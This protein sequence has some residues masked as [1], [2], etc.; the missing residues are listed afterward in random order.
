MPRARRRATPPRI[1]ND[2]LESAQL[3]GL[4][5]VGEGSAGIAR[6]RAG[7]SFTYVN[8]QGIRV[9]HTETL[10]R[11]RSLAIPPAWTEVWICASPR[12]HVQAVGRDARRRKQY[13]YHPRWR[14]VRDAAKYARMLAFARALPAIRARVDRDLAR[15]GLP[16]EKVLAAVVRLLDLTLIRVGNAEYARQN[17]SFGL[18]TMRDEHVT[19]VGSTLSFH[20]RGKSGK[21][22]AVTIRDARLAR[23]VR[24]CQELPGRSLF[25]WIGADGVRQAI[26]SADVNAYLREAA[27]EE[28]TAKDF[29]TW[30][31]TVLAAM[32]L[33][34]GETFTSQRQARR[35]IA[36]AVA[37]VARRLGN[38]PAVCRKGYVH[39][40]VIDAYLDGTALH[41]FRRRALRAANGDGAGLSA[42]EAVV[43]GMLKSR[44]T[45][46]PETRAA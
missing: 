26:D 2:P 46:A 45:P 23:I 34:D 19:L 33:A 36:A 35:N 18:T 8:A 41:G 14:E 12:G 29:R 38:T 4:T 5:Y 31:G 22:H 9:R 21:E 10:T 16:R 17:R 39:P 11:I 44:L 42:D 27:G 40:A 37:S 24:R 25:Q 1:V 28:F 6:R 30:A 15:P 32:A 3:A 43:L 20:F 13:R 7:N